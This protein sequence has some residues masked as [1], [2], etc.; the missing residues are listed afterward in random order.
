VRVAA[1]SPSCVNLWIDSHLELLSVKRGLRIGLFVIVPL[2]LIAGGV[3]GVK[4]RLRKPPPKPVTAT[5]ERGRVLVK[6]SETG[7][8]EPLTKVEV[9]SK[10]SGRIKDMRVEE[11]DLVTQGQV[12]AVLEVPDLEAQQAQMRAQLRAADRRVEEAQ[13][14][15]AV[16][17]ERD[18]RELERSRA[19]VQEAQARL[20]DLKAGSR[21][22]EI[23]QAQSDVDQAQARLTEAEQLLKRKQDLLDRGFIAAQ[24]VD[25]ARTE[26]DAAQAVYEGSRQRLA[27]LKEGP[28]TDQV[29]AAQWQLQQAQAAVALAEAERKRERVQLATIEETK[30]S[31]E[32]IAKALEEVDTTLADAVV[33]APRSGQV[34]QANIRAGELIT[35]GVATFTSGMTICTIGDMSKM[36]V[37]V[38][39]NE[40]DIAKIRLGMP[41][42]IELDSIRGRTFHG[43]VTRVAPAA[44]GSGTAAPQPPGQ[45]QVV[46]FS[47]EVQFTDAT[48]EVRPGMTASVTMISAERR[49]ALYLPN[50]AIRRRDGRAYVLRMASDVPREVDVTTGLSN[51]ADTEII[52]GLHQGDRALLGKPP[53]MPARKKIEIHAGPNDRHGGR[54]R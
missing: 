51:D 24:D 5:V 7:A 17:V 46:R 13:E 8:V 3:Y 31:R 22:Q 23:A 43:R 12:I 21:V 14:S 36:L 27:L 6:V 1:F 48:A 26:R 44:F 53:G 10:V 39:V 52:S 47:V 40:V 28:R 33:T 29:Q 34:I 16:Q 37:R 50:D 20:A 4:L 19:A 49:D 2:A 41:A 9:K 42:E 38:Y 18:K 54:P 32:Q 45:A 11:G 35:S 30:A 25:S 15:Y